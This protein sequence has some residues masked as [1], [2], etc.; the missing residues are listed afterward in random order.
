MVK[1]VKNNEKTINDGIAAEGWSR[2][3]G[4]GGSHSGGPGGSV[5][6]GGGRRP[7]GCVRST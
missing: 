7:G 1:M 3:W 5:G 6:G 4:G 2:I